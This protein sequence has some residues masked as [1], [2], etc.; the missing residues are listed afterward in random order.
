MESLI[1]SKHVPQK[2]AGGR[3]HRVA[4][5]LA[6]TKKLKVGVSNIRNLQTETIC[7]DAANFYYTLSHPYARLVFF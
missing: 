7:A 5:C 1:T 2:I 6:L 3:R 4:T